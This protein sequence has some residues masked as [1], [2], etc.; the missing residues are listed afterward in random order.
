[1]RSTSLSP[2][3][4]LC[5]P[6]ALEAFQK[7]VEL[8]PTDPRGRY[9]LAVKKDIDGDHQGSI[10]DLLAL[11]SDTPPGAPWESDV[12][13]TI[14][15]IGAI[16][17]SQRLETVIAARAPQVA[18]PGSGAVAGDAASSNL[19]GPTAQQVA[20]ARNMTPGQ[21]EAMVAGMVESLEQ[22]LQDEPNNLD[23]WVM[24]M[25]SRM[26]LGETGKARRALE[27]AV[28]ANPQYAPQLRDQAAQLG[29]E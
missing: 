2:Q 17:V 12:A 20:D 26:T 1:M 19:R 3:R 14:Q 11:L 29:I 25:R 28:A 22:R 27:D 4:T 24:L 21:Q 16:D 13:R 5:P 10:T 23:G 6:I 7:A 9:F 18:V 15:Q 8:D